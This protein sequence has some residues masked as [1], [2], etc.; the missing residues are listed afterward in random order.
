MFAMMK[1]KINTRSQAKK[2]VT[3][4]QGQS[5][6]HVVAFHGEG[7][8]ETSQNEG[9]N[10][11]HVRVS[12]TISRT[13]PKEREQEQGAHG[14]HGQWHGLGDPPSEN[15]SNHRKHPLA[16]RWSIKLHEEAYDEGQQGS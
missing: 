13:Y 12:N 9:N 10:I 5:S 7:K 1:K 6:V 3:H 16:A 11:V 8:Y 15:P 4:I 14:C 2:G